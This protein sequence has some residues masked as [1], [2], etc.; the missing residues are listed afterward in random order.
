MKY[1]CRAVLPIKTVAQ[2][3]TTSLFMYAYTKNLYSARKVLKQDL[4][5]LK[6]NTILQDKNSNYVKANRELN[7]KYLQIILSS[8]NDSIS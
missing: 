1:H 4:T 6:M 8:I 3:L 5:A 2:G 7:G